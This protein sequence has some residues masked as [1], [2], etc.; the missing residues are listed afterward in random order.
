MQLDPNLKPTAFNSNDRG[1]QVV[2]S[3]GHESVYVWPWVEQVVTAKIDPISEAWNR[4]ELF[5]SDV[6]NK[7]N[8]LSVPYE[9]VIQKGNGGRGMGKLM[10]KIKSHGFAFVSN[11]PV[12]PAATEDLLEHIGPIR[13]T[14]Y[15]GFYDFI[16][17]L[18]SADTAYTNLA[19]APHTDTTYFTEPAGLQAFHMLSHEPPPGQD[20]DKD[21]LGGESVLVDGF[22][23]AVEMKRHHHKHYRTLCGTSVPW[24][25]SGNLEHS[26]TPNR[27]YPVI[28]AGRNIR[29][30]PKRIRWNNDDRG[31]VPLHE[32]EGWYAAAK[33]W[34]SYVQDPKYQYWFQLE[35]GSVLIFDNWRLLHGRRAFEGR[36][37]VC[38]AYINRDDFFSKWKLTTNRKDVEVITHNLIQFGL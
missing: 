18:A 22:S 11:T 20:V 14:H 10:E 9:E 17:D 3:D 15:G 21:N 6:G 33:V 38:G 35:P 16:P 32:A 5:E 1:L 37:R 12:D 23:I 26:I 30:L 27:R 28:E 34:N 19:L 4:R 36:R 31:A 8:Q 2:W 24:H 7:G 29:L 25:A 13:N